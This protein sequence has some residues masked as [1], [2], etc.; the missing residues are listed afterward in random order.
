MKPFQALQDCL[1]LVNSA[2]KGSCITVIFF[3]LTTAQVDSR[4]PQPNYILV[5]SLY[6][7]VLLDKGVFNFY[8]CSLYFC[9][10][11]VH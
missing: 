10:W 11:N 6:S 9:Q 2:N 7:L 5:N 1:L 8:Q 3:F 4:H